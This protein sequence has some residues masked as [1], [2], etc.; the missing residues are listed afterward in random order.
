M[1][2][3]EIK[4][5]STDK[6]TVM[7]RRLIICSFS[8]LIAASSLALA[9]ATESEILSTLSEAPSDGQIDTALIFTNLG[10][11]TAVVGV[12]GFARSGEPTGSVRVKVPARGVAYVLASQLRPTTNAAILGHAEAVS[13]NL[14]V[15]GTAV[16][17]GIGTTD[18]PV[19]TRT[20]V[21]PLPVPE[22]TPEPATPSVSNQSALRYT[23]MI[24]PV[25]AAN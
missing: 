23:R 15:V 13:R 12:R 11:S 19:I 21:G 3:F 4:P 14:G 22:A 18:L 2:L 20:A 24:F 6:E 16:L 25:I 1:L 8:L 9:Q 5:Q 10:R 7:I 17:V